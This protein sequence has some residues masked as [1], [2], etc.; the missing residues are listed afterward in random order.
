MFFP[1][2]TRNYTITN[3]NLI[4]T[5]KNVSILCLSR[6]NTFNEHFSKASTFVKMYDLL[7]DLYVFFSRSCK[8]DTVL[9]E[10]I[11]QVENALKLRN[12]SKTR[13]VYR[14]ESIEAVWSSFEAIRNALAEVA[15]KDN[16][17]LTRSKSASLRKK[18]AKFDFIFALMFMRLIMR[19]TKILT[20]QRQKP[21][22]N[23]LDGLTMIDQTVT[24]LERIRNT[25]SELNDQ[26]NASVEFAEKL[27]THP[28][29]E[30]A[31]TSGRRMSRRLDDNPETS[32]AISLHTSYRKCM[33]EVLDSL[34]T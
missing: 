9:R 25:E 27:G 18:M 10:H 21:E 14:S 24:S 32:A 17:A 28:A 1:N 6:S 7:E 11:K 4:V 26:I 16:D 3:T 19:M 8:R 29:D 22:L 12:L 33:I 5:P 30:F 13:W 23:I 15:Q 2:C 34:I 20:V 31:K